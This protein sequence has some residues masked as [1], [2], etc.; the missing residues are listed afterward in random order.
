MLKSYSRWIRAAAGSWTISGLITADAGLPYSVLDGGDNSFTGLGHDMADIVYGVS[1]TAG[2]TELRKLNYAAFTNN[3]PGTYGNSGRNTFRSDPI[4]NV[5]LALMK[6]FPVVTEWTQLTFRAE[7]FN[8][9][10]H[11]NFYA[12]NADYNSGPLNFGVITGA[13]DPRILQLALKLNF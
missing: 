10:N 7:A 4:V 1:P 11:P 8:A 13:R 9:L 3:A 5:D 2:S 12:P 6:T